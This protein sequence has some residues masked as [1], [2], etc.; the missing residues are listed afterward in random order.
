MASIV[1]PIHDLPYA[2]Q[3][4]HATL[5][6]IAQAQFEAPFVTVRPGQA[7]DVLVG[8]DIYG[9]TLSNTRGVRFGNT[10]SLVPV[11]PGRTAGGEGASP[12]YFAL[13]GG[14]MPFRRR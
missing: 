6:W 7:Y 1:G 4:H 11:R 5:Y 13:D 14:T 3:C 8:Q 9:D 10:C 12:L 2:I